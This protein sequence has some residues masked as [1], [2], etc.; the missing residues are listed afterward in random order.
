METAFPPFTKCY[1]VFTNIVKSNKRIIKWN[2]MDIFIG[3]HFNMKEMLQGNQRSIQCDAVYFLFVLWSDSSLLLLLP[4]SPRLFLLLLSRSYSC[5]QSC[6]LLLLSPPLLQLQ[7][8]MQIHTRGKQKGGY[9]PWAAVLKESLTGGP[10]A[11]PH[12]HGADV[13]NELK[14]RCQN[15]L[16]HSSDHFKAR[17][18]TEL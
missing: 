2:V 1:L 16:S 17:Q 18:S 10:P 3:I 14:K 15:F 8:H 7:R 6:H 9:F 13:W 4:L 5:L 12:C 11:E